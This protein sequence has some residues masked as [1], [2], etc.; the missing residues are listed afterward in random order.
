MY[1]MYIFRLCKLC[2]DGPKYIWRHTTELL[3][4][5]ELLEL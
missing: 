1:E 2:I 3:E 4:L 5:L